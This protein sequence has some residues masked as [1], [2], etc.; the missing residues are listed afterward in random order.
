MFKVNSIRALILSFTMA[1]V[2]AAHAQNVPEYLYVE[3]TKGGDVT[4][5][6]I[7]DHEVIGRIPESRIGGHPDDV[8]ASKNGE[9][10]YVNRETNE[11]VLAISTKTEEVLFR[12]PVTGIPHH[13]TLSADERYLFVPI[14]NY[15]RLDVIDLR[16]RKVI[17][18]VD[19]GWGAHGTRLSPDGKRLY[20][21][22]IFHEAFVIIDVESLE[23]E[24]AIY[25]PEGVRPF[26]ISPDEK[27]IYVQLS[28]VHGI[29]VV[30]VESGEILQTVHM[31]PEITPDQLKQPFPFTVNHGLAITRDGGMLLSA[32]SITDN[33]VVYS[34]PDFTRLADIPVG[35]EP[36]WIIFNNDERFAYVTN[37]RDDTLS[38]ISMTELKEIK[39]IK[40]VGDYPQRLDTAYVPNREVKK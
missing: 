28:N 6:S 21:G 10:I 29:A 27:L 18:S 2:G 16:E 14:F 7:P 1:A 4:V 34:L 17:K 9:V 38:V 23:V 22:H 25:M 33:V 36:N 8:I 5:I 13:M 30:D 19:V 12:V 39:R 35:R 31:P 32:G 11:D 15:P 20:V 26:E 24:R 37:R 3:N 40:D